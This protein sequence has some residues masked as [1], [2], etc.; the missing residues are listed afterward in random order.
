MSSGPIISLSLDPEGR[1]CSLPYLRRLVPDKEPADQES[2]PPS[3]PSCFAGSFFREASTNA[4]ASLGEIPLILAAFEILCRDC[5]SA[6]HIGRIMALRNRPILDKVLAH[7]ASSA[8]PMFP[9]S[10]YFRTSLQCGLICVPHAEH[11]LS[12][13]EGGIPDALPPLI[14]LEQVVDTLVKERA[15]NKLRDQS[16]ARHRMLLLFPA[17]IT[18]GSL[19]REFTQKQL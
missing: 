16:A 4:K 1:P 11:R 12:T 15:G 9:S 19:F 7:L 6:P 18:V 10:R 8:T 5:H 14:I 17:F 2:R 13:F 3:T